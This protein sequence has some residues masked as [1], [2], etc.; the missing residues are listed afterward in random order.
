MRPDVVLQRR[1]VEIADEDRARS[2]VL[3]GADGVHLGDEI[4]LVAELRVDLRVRLVAAGGDVEI[5]DEDRAA[6]GLDA[7]REVAAV[8]DVAE[9]AASR[10]SRAAGARWSRR[11]DSPSGRGSRC[12]RS[13]ALEAPRR[14]TGRPG[15]S[16]PA[17]RARPARCSAS[18]RST[19]GMRRRTE[20][21]FQVAMEKGMGRSGRE[22]KRRNLTARR[23]TTARPRNAAL[24]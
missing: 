23:Q 12:A 17:G 7:D 18:R 14:G 2:L 9:I 5:V 16:S 24:C 1:D 19:S 6:A 4:E 10:R 20:L 21:M 8:A 13:R 11:R 15:T 22:S 3:L